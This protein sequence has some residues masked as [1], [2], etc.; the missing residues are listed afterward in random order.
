MCRCFF[1]SLQMMEAQGSPCFSVALSLGISG[2]CGVQSLCLYLQSL[3]FFF[4]VPKKKKNI[5]NKKIY[6]NRKKKKKKVKE[7]ENKP[8][9][10]HLDIFQ[11]L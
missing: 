2:L 4:N 9:H 7:T 3:Q 10:L 8:I 6:R 5:K 11:F 1:P